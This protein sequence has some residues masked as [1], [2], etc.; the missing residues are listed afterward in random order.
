MD[1]FNNPMVNNALKSMTSEQIKNYKTIGEHM[2][3]NVNFVD[4]DLINKLHPPIEESVAYVE[5]GIKSGLLPCD[6]TEDEVSLLCNSFGPK[7]F[8]RY[9]FQ[10]HEV[11]EVGLSLKMKTEIDE[12]IEYKIAEAIE[13]RKLKE[14]PQKLTKIQREHNRKLE[15]KR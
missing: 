8:E 14:R 11:P 6:L 2:Y 15:N 3:G 5:E 4:S 1:L 13:L 12:A 7:W 10:E 9:G